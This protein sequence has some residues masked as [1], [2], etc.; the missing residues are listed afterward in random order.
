M[1]KVLDNELI[2]AIRER[3]AAKNHLEIKHKE[4]KAFDREMKEKWN[5]LEQKLNDLRADESRHVQFS[6][7]SSKYEIKNKNC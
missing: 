2:L 1:P 4:K 6:L 7:A 3:D 5:D